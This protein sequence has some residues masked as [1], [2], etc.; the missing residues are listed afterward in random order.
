MFFVALKDRP[1]GREGGECADIGWHMFRLVYRAID[2]AHHRCF[3]FMK[4]NVNVSA[5]AERP[6]IAHAFYHKSKSDMVSQRG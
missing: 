4:N 6:Y 1:W 5:K 2:I 3:N